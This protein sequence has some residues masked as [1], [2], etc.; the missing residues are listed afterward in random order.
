[1]GKVSNNDTINTAQTVTVNVQFFDRDDTLL[2]SNSDGT[3]SLALGQTWSFKISA[4]PEI[5]EYL[6][7]SESLP[8]LFLIASFH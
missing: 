7:F 4:S 6:I 2:G 8:T 5:L 1:M 3:Y